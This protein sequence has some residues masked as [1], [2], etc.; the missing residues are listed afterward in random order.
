MLSPEEQISAIATAAMESAGKEVVNEIQQRISRT[1]PP[2]SDPYT[3]PHLR[4]GDLALGIH[5][6]VD[7]FHDGVTLTI[8][9]DMF[10][11][12]FLHYGTKKMQW[13]D[14]FRGNDLLLLVDTTHRVLQTAFTPHGAGAPANAINPAP[15]NL[16]H[17]FG[18]DVI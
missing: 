6:T 8:I 15:A 10:Y 16:S 3:P 4:T 5:H 18:V 9:S 1:F 2:A 13:R 11:S 12:S 14:L 7:E 17:I